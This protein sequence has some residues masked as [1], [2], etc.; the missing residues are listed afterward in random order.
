MPVRGLP[1]SILDFVSVEAAT[2]ERAWLWPFLQP[3]H[4][5]PAAW[6]REP[7][8]ETANG[9]G[10]RSARHGLFVMVSGAVELDGRRWVHVSLSRRDRLPSYDDLALVKRAFLGPDTRAIQL[11]V[12]EAEHVN[13]HR[14]CLHLWHC[15]DGDGLP[16]FRT[17]GEV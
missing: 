6:K 11:F 8:A 10:W 9:V 3:P 15:V 4:I 7:R 2:P 16:D 13:R 1:M 12:P 14:F 5:A 17:M